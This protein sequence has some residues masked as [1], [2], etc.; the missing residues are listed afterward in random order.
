MLGSHL[1][2]ILVSVV[3]L[4]LVCGLQGVDASE[5]TKVPGKVKQLR[6]EVQ[7]TG[8]LLNWEPVSGCDGYRLYHDTGK[9]VRE[10]AFWVDVDGGQS[11]YLF[12][13]VVKGQ[14]YSFRVAALRGRSEGPS[15]AP[16]KVQI[17]GN[18]GILRSDVGE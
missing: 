16:V 7:S 4:V 11:T 15:S 3:A 2:T 5:G 9:S 18:P 1:R 6:A 8:V 13:E 10:G 17:T 12:A 14:E